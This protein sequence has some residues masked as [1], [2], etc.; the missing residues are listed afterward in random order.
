MLLLEKLQIGPAEWQPYVGVQVLVGIIIC[1]CVCVCSCSPTRKPEDKRLCNKGLI[2]DWMAERCV[3]YPSSKQGQWVIDFNSRIATSCS[4]LT[5]KCLGYFLLYVS[6]YIAG[7][8]IQ[9]K[10][11]KAHTTTNYFIFL[12]IYYIC[13]NTFLFYLY[14]FFFLYQSLRLLSVRRTVRLM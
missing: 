3:T 4:G 14:F 7:T 1:V 2:W 11:I 10:H 9:Y 8:F 5:N 12:H 6:R 13:D